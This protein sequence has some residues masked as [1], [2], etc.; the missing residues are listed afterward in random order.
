MGQNQVSFIERCA[1][2]GGYFWEVSLIAAVCVCV[3]VAG[4]ADGSR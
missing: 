2:F 1:S 3:C 4:S